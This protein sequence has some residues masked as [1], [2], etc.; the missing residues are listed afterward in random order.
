[1]NLL[2]KVNKV[3]VVLIEAIVSLLLVTAIV[4][5]TYGIFSR[6]LQ[7]L[8]VIIWTEELA[9]YCIIT[10]VFLVSGLSIRYGLHLGIDL[11]IE[12]LPNTFQKVWLTILNL[13]TVIVL[14]IIAIETFKYVQ[15]AGF[16]ISPALK[17]PMSIP[18]SIIAIGIS[19]IILEL[20]ASTI[21]KWKKKEE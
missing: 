18:Y 11:L 1:M 7:F 21:S 12:K 10:M 5:I 9:R 2:S 17:M 6:M 13:F 3:Y 4:S 8:P 15:V 19:L 20:L 14:S 16:R